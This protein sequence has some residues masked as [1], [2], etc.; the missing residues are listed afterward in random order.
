MLWRVASP[1]GQIVAVCQEVPAFD[2]PGYD[3]RLERPEGGLMRQL[4]RSGDGD[5]CTE[6]VW[7]P[8]GRTLAVLS[9][10]V[11][12]VRFVDV[13]WALDH[14]E[15]QTAYWS[16]R[17]VDLSTE[18]ARLEGSELRFVG[19]TAIELQVCSARS[20]GSSTSRGTD[21]LTRRLDIPLPIGHR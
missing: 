2:G 5:P 8:D 18:R 3:V 9:G 13:G 20:G 12:R 1:N 14:P 16:W 6:V 10:H 21:S 17:Q 15:V 19:P 11:A 7:S 4:Y